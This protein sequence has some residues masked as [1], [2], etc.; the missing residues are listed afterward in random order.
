MRLALAGYG[1]LGVTILSSILNNTSCEVVAVLQNGRATKPWKRPFSLLF[2]RIA[3][4]KDNIAKYALKHRIPVIWINRMTPD[5]LQPLK[6]LLP[7][8]IITSGFSIIFKKQLLS[9]PRIGCINVHSSLLPNHRGPNPFSAVILQGE[10]ES[11]VTFH[12]MDE[13]IDT[14]PI[15][16]QERF[17]ITESDTAY[18]VYCKASELAGKMVPQVLAKIER[19]GLIGVPQDNEIA[20]YD[21]KPTL[22]DALI[23]WDVPA[24][25]IDRQVRALSQ[26]IMPRFIYKRKTVFVSKVQVNRANT[27]YPPGTVMNPNYPAEIATAEGSVKLISAF[28]LFP[29][30]RLWPKKGLLK[31][32]DSI[33]I[34]DTPYE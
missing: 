29:F 5:E 18:T 30:P 11:G 13:G 1:R 27:S 24:I 8:I 16:A 7:D 32:G 26:I 21:P 14:G 15:I 25:H 2:S 3:G 9:L 31:I 4:G 23:R 34:E 22:K 12:I 19:E 6:E 10:S 17:P 33:L 28:T 20:T